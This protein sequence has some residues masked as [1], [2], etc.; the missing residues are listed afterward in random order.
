MSNLS[1]LAAIAV[2]WLFLTLF[3]RHVFRN[4]SIAP[5]AWLMIIG[6][7]YAFGQRH[8]FPSLPAIHLTPEVILVCIFPVIIFASGRLMNMNVLRRETVP[9]LFFSVFGVIASMF[10]IGVPLAYFAGIPLLDSLF[11]GSAL[12][13]TDPA[14]VSSVLQRFGLKEDIQHIIEGESLFNDGV[15]L[16]LYAAMAGIV[17]KG[18]DIKLTVELM[19]FSWTLGSSLLLGG[20]LGAGA[21]LFLRLWKNPD[22]HTQ[23]SFSLILAYS[24]YLI[25]ENA[26]HLSGILSVLS[27]SMLFMI[28]ISPSFREED[29]FFG[30]TWSYLCMLFNS[31]LFFAIGTETGAHDFPLTW[32]LLIAIGVLIA[33]RVILI[34]TGS[35]FLR[36]VQFKISLKDQNL[37]ILTGLRGALSVTLLLMIP[38]E[39]EFRHLFLCLSFVMILFPLILQPPLLKKYL[40]R[41]KS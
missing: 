16:T 23:F 35:L 9:I 7:A 20:I 19:N 30:D 6:I 31:F 1:L 14:A 22:Y 13:A 17:L 40:S 26:F 4:S 41:K 10:F 28:T 24:A 2:S 38:D 34:Y 8:Y 27:A 15:A 25:A 21:G 11:F 39:Y 33:S 12:A 36:A 18:T 29:E 32:L 37:L 3:V 5:D